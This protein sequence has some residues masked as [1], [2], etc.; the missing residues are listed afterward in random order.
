MVEVP[1]LYLITIT[2]FAI[3]GIVC[4]ANWLQRKLEVG[5]VLALRWLNARY[6]AQQWPFGW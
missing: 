1:T 4:S 2:A 5:R 6:L 3:V